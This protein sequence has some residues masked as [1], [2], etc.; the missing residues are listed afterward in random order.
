M[1]CAGIEP[2]L[3]R[4]RRVFPPLRQIGHKKNRVI[5]EEGLYVNMRNTLVSAL[6]SC[7]AGWVAS[8]WSDTTS[9]NRV[10]FWIE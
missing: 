5:Q 8:L 3:L 4:R 10:H 2:A 6:H 7:E 9:F 1:H